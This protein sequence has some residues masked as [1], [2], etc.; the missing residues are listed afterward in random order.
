MAKLIT[1][2]A[3]KKAK[4]YFE[5]DDA[6]IGRAAKVF[7]AFIQDSS[8]KQD[9][10]HQVTCA[11]A[12]MILIGQMVESNVAHLDLKLDD[13]THKDAPEGNWR[14]RIDRVKAA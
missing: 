4:T 11:S 5:W 10:L 3:E 2:A 8:K 9:G 12:A 1:T 13:F 6:S 14:I 7:A